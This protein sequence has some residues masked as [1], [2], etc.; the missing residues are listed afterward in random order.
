MAKNTI[1]MP[2]NTLFT[3]TQYFVWNLNQNNFESLDFTKQNR[4]KVHEK[5]KKKIPKSREK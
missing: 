4:A 3:F 2:F 1:P 5:K